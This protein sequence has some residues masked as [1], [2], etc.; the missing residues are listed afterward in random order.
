MGF[1]DHLPCLFISTS[2]QLPPTRCQCRSGTQQ[3]QLAPGV[4]L[5]VSGI[6]PCLVVLPDPLWNSWLD[7]P[8]AGDARLVS[9]LFT[10]GIAHLPTNNGMIS[11]YPSP[12]TDNAMVDFVFEQATPVTI[13]VYNALGQ[14][15]FSKQYDY[16][17][18]ATTL[19][20]LRDAKGL[21]FVQITT[22][23]HSLTR[24]VVKQ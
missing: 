7:G 6:R 3:P 20:P 4:S 24:T 14:M 21:Y 2:E 23:K 16:S 18:Q 5:G 19:L 11:V 13:K 17:R 22:P 12:T 15:V 9:T 10:I 1:H 8:A